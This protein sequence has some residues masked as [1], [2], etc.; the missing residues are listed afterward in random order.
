MR[1]HTAVL[2]GAL[3][4]AVPIVVIACKKDDAAP[5]PTTPTAYPSGSAYGAYGQ[6]PPAGYPQQTGPQGTYPQA[7]AT[8]PAATPPVPGQLAVPGPAALPCSNDSMCMTHKCNTQFGKCAF[9]CLS[10]ADCIQ[11]SSCFVAGGALAACIPKPP[12]T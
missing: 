9:P 1:T 11:G 3:V 4:V 2:F 6:Q 8:A 10:D 12:G 5:Q 7:T